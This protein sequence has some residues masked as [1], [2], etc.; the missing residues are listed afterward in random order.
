MPNC[1]VWYLTVSWKLYRK[2][3]EEAFSSWFLTCSLQMPLAISDIVPEIQSF[4]SFRHYLLITWA[5]FLESASLAWRA[6]TCDNVLLHSPGPGRPLKILSIPH[7]QLRSAD[8]W[9]GWRAD[10]PLPT[11]QQN[12]V[13]KKKKK[14]GCLMQLVSQQP[15]PLFFFGSIWGQ[16]NICIWPIFMIINLSR[17]FSSCAPS[18]QKIVTALMKVKKRKEKK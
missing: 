2:G 5:G 6:A 14:T 18:S 7:C 13:V 9:D 16:W 1:L 17:L 15:C 4:Q 8:N 11:A 10:G 12:T 3:W